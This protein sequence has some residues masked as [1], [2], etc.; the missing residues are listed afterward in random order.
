MNEKIFWNFLETAKNNISKTT[1][2]LSRTKNAQPKKIIQT[3][4]SEIKF[5]VQPIGSRLFIQLD[6]KGKGTIHD[7]FGAYRVKICRRNIMKIAAKAMAAINSVRSKNQILIL[8]INL[9]LHFWF[10][11]LVA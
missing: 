6:M 9:V 11:D 4:N 7:I 3:H 1:C 8:F 10:D 5:T 2:S